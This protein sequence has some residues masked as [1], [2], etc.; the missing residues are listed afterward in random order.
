MSWL[1][2]VPVQPPRARPVGKIT[3]VSEAARL[4][5]DGDIVAVGGGVGDTTGVISELEE[6]FLAETGESRYSP[7]DLT[8]VFASSQGGGRTRGL[9]H[10]AHPGLVRRVISGSWSQP[11]RLRDLAVANRIEAYALP[12]GAI[13]QMWRA[14]A[15][16][17]PGHVTRV[18][19]G[20]P[21]DPNRGGG[22]INARTKE[23]IVQRIIASGANALFYRALPVDV[24]IIQAL[25]ADSGGNVTLRRDA[26]RHEVLAIA[27]ATRASGGTVIVQ[28]DRI[29]PSRAPRASDAAIPASLVDWIVV[30]EPVDLLWETFNPPVGNL[31]DQTDT[32]AR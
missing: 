19:L 29:I 4:I 27:M 32:S 15:V 18:G 11:P 6:M 30:T 8:L 25:T 3:S 26:A 22:R 20:T 31:P 13:I 28:V 1:T 7:R 24:G 17:R 12:R 2:H 14:A 21:A 16:Q 10:L 5:R 23:E 9:N